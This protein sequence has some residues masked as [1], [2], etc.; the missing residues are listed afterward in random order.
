MGGVDF[1]NITWDDN[2]IYG[3]AKVWGTE[4]WHKIKVHRINEEFEI[5]PGN[6][7]FRIKKALWVIA[8]RLKEKNKLNENEVVAWG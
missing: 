6:Y 1:R 2:Y 8:R 4:Q 7:D 5:I 3:E